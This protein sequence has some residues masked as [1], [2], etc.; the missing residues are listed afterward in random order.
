MKNCVD[1]K[2]LTWKGHQPHAVRIEYGSIPESGPR[3]RSTPE[4]SRWSIKQPGIIS[5]SKPE[6]HD[7]MLL[8]NSEK[9]ILIFGICS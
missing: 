2:F 6:G 8:V 3:P 5:E 1:E 7:N 4:D 9:T